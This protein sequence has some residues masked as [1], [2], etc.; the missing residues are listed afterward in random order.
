[1]RYHQPAAA[2]LFAIDCC[3]L[4]KFNAEKTAE[5]RLKVP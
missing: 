5:R 3:T 4:P 2:Y 1:M